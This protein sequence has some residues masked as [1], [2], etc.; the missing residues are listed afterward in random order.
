MKISVPFVG[1]TFGDIVGCYY[2]LSLILLPVIIG[3]AIFGFFPLP[4]VIFYLLLF[5]GSHILSVYKSGD[6][7][8]QK[9]VDKPGQAC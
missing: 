2:V 1:R 9:G 5:F 4:L 6:C 3:L 8:K 7:S